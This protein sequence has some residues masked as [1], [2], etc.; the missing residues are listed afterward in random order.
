MLWQ[1]D[2]VGR[3][4]AKIRIYKVL[5]QKMDYKSEVIRINVWC[6]LFSAGGV[7]SL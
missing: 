6:Y 5:I 2:V 3:R 1:A 4:N 7:T